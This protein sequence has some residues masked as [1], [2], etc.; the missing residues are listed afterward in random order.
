MF[1]GVGYKLTKKVNIGAELNYNFGTIETKNLFFVNGVQFGTRELNYSDVRGVSFST[2]ITY[3]TKINK[4]YDFFSGFSYSPQANLSSKN[5]R[6]ISTV[7]FY[8]QGAEFV[9]DSEDQVVQNTTIKLPTKISFGAGIGV[10][11]KWLIGSEIRFQNTSVLTNRFN[12]IDNVKFENSTSFSFGGYYIPNYNSYANYFKRVTYRAGLRYENTGLIIENKSIE[13][14]AGI[15]GMGLPL[16]GTF[17][18]IN[19]G[20][21]IGKKGTIYNGLIQNNY[22]NIIIGLSFSEKWFIRRKYN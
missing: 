2:G 6:N 8:S 13:D 4:K 20:I 15:I 5:S 18:N 7:Q 9:I 21:E 19:I 11:K 14:F 17:S 1:L 22:T 3:Q 16:S 12:D 10:A